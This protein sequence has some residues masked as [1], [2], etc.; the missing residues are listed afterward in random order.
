MTRSPRG[1]RKTRE[2]PEAVPGF[3][4]DAD[5]AQRVINFI[6]TFCVMS[7]GQQWAGRPMEL[8][9]WQKRDIIEPLFG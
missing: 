7:K 1:S 9:E 2:R 5:R 3:V 4:F 8:M 6:Q